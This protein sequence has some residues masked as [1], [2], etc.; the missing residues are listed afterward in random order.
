MP[1]NNHM[2][3]RHFLLVLTLVSMV[4]TNSNAERV[5]FSQLYR[6]FYREDGVPGGRELWRIWR[7]SS[8]ELHSSGIDDDLAQLH[9]RAYVFIDGRSV[10][11]TQKALRLIDRFVE[12]HI[13]TMLPE[14]AKAHIFP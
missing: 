9:E 6:H 5:P 13:R 1:L 11:P 14:E 4:G 2:C 7:D 12:D 8:R 3:D 10:M